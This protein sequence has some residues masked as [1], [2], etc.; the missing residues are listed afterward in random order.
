MQGRLT[1]ASLDSQSVRSAIGGAT[2]QGWCRKDGLASTHVSALTDAAGYF[3]IDC[4]DDEPSFSGGVALQN[5]TATMTV[6]PN[7]TIWLYS[8]SPAEVWMSANGIARV[9]QIHNRYNPDAAASFAVSTSPVSFAVRQ[10]PSDGFS[11]YEYWNN[12]IR[13]A[14]YTP[15]SNAQYSEV[16]HEYGHALHYFGLD[17]YD[18]WTCNPDP[19]SAH[20]PNSAYTPECAFGEGFAIFFSLVAL[21]NESSAGPIN[22]LQSYEVNSNRLL[23]GNGL[24]KSGMVA[25]AMLDIVDDATWND[26]QSGDDDPL[27]GV[28]LS[29][30]VHIIKDCRLPRTNGGV[31][32]YSYDFIYCAESSVT[33]YLGAPVN[34]QSAWFLYPSLSWDVAPSLPSAAGVRSIWKFNF[35]NL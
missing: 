3:S 9:W 6:S 25:S 33:A 13:I 15:F 23:G 4:A 14:S 34:Y 11:N 20:D 12:L 24:L 31:M 22:I 7:P 17:H 8:G 35:Y 16:T 2:V 32:R 29:Q 18:S 19:N 30:L 27:A 5:S 10:Q 1:Y 28:T 21:R 26:G